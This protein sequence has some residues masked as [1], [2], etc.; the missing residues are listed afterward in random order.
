M[1]GDEAGAIILAQ[2]RRGFLDLVKELG[3]HSKD[4]KGTLKVFKQYSS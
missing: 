1:V 2:I 4:K 3:L